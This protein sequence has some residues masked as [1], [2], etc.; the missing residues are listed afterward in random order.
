MKLQWTGLHGDRYWDISP[1]CPIFLL[2][3]L[4]SLEISCARIGQP[5]SGP[6]GSWDKEWL[7]EYSGKTRLTS[8]ELIEC[9]VSIEALEA[10]LSLPAALE[11]LVLCETARHEVA[12]RDRF[13][14]SESELFNRA[15]GQ[16]RDTIQHLQIMACPVYASMSGRID[17]PLALALGEF[18]ALT[19]LRLGPFRTA[20]RTTGQ[21][22]DLCT[23]SSPAPPAL[24]HLRLDEFLLSLLARRPT[25]DAVLSELLVDDLIANAMARPG[26]KPLQVEVSL[27]RMTPYLNRL[28]RIREHRPLVRRLVEDFAKNF[29]QRQPQYRSRP[30]QDREERSPSSETERGS[31]PGSESSA[32]PPQSSGAGSVSDG[33]TSSAA[34]SIDPTTEPRLRILTNKHVPVI[35]PYLYR[36]KQPQSMTRYDSWHPQR[37]VPSAELTYMCGAESEEDEDNEDPDPVVSFFLEE[38]ADL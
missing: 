26:G 10:L 22:P 4:Q 19:S 17:R 5:L 36:E 21:R 30:S 24:Q 33:A 38:Y 15:I 20:P 31:S 34:T 11:R 13:A 14:T 29:R 27:A 6:V 18:R 25:A 23:L 2:P 9:T 16:Q 12:L 1:A 7:R 28:P 35:P 37:F 8:L 32:S 3:Q